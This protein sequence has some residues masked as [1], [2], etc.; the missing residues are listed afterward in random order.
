VRNLASF[1]TSLNFELPAFENAARYPN[2][3][4]NILCRRMIAQCFRRSLVN[5]VHAPLRTVCQSCPT[6]KIAERK[7][8]KLS[9]TQPRIIRFRSNFVQSLNTWHAKCCKG[10]WSRGQRSRSQRDNV[11]KNSQNHQ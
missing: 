11:C 9:I 2:A 1:S 6:H 3:E 5:W 4:T 8:T 7:R 10:S